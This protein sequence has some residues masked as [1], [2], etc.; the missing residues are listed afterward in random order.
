MTGTATAPFTADD[1]RA[2]MERAAREAADAASPDSS[3]RPAPTS[4]G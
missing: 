2:R 3:W 4:Y 1:Y